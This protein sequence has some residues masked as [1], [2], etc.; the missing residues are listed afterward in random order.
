M[1][2]NVIDPVEQT[3]VP[4]LRGI[5]T[6]SL[7][8]A[9]LPFTEAYE[10]ANKVRNKL[11]PDA[12]VS[13]QEITRL[14]SRLL[15]KGGYDEALVRYRRADDPASPILVYERDGAPLPFSKGRLSQSLEICAFPSDECY[16][17]TSEIEQ[18]LLAEGV[19][20][21]SSTELAR[22]THAYLKAHQPPEMA[23]RYLTWIAFT[24][25]GRPL[26]LLLGG[27]TGSGKSTIGSEI[28][29]RLN[30]VRT[31]STDML[32]E[33]MR[34]MVPRRLLPALHTSSFTAWETL[35]S[36]GD[37][38]VRFETHFIDGYLTQAREVAVA[39][40]GVYQRA[41]T[42]RLSIIVEGVHVYPA[43][44]KRIAKEEGPLVVP[45]LLAV[46]KRKQ[47]R[48]QIQGRGQFVSS[49]RAERYLDHFD[50]IWELQSFLLAEADRHDIPILPNVDLTETTR[51]AMETISEYLAREFTTEPAE[52]F[53]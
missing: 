6:R 23:Q 21:I 40:E 18:Q 31:Q 34:L 15:E 47:L 48:K 45:M 46:L 51:L 9:G 22:R 42:E 8:E 10:I 1:S 43:L 36:R 50:A 24:R 26:V 49:R 20:E 41:V 38:P 19:M 7:R 30:I 16:A 2:I 5:L 4:F 27:T 35:P 29:H 37:A 25:S 44:Q 12:E 28:A 52:V 3:R 32:R 17:I 33:V 13:P 14:V 11:G 53:A 39:I